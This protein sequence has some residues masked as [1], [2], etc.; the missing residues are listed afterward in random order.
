MDDKKLDPR[1]KE[2]IDL[3][4]EEIPNPGDENIESLF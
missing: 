3:Y 2:S 4:V 1:V